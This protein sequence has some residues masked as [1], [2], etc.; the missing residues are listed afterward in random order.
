MTKR[1]FRSTFLAVAVVLVASIVIIMGVMYDYF[2]GVQW[3]Q[4]DAETELASSGVETGG[5]DYLNDLNLRDYRVTWIDSNGTVIFDNQANAGEMENHSD[6]TEVREALRTGAGKSTRYSSTLS[7]KTFYRAV[8]LSDGTVLRVSATQYSVFTILLGMLPPILGVVAVALILSAVI[9]RRLSKNIVEPINKIDFDHP[10]DNEA[11]EELAPFLSRIE[12]QH[13]Q[14]ESQMKDLEHMQ[15]EFLAVTESMNEG[16]ILLNEKG[17]VLSINKAARKLFSAEGS[18]VGKDILTIEWSLDVQRLLEKAVSGSHGEIMLE[19]DGREYQLDASPVMTGGGKVSGAVLLS[20]DVTEKAFSERQ[21]REFSANVSHELKTPLHSIMG[22]AELLENGLVKKEDV[23]HFIGTIRREA[24]RLVTLID[25]IIRLS[26]LDEGADMQRENVDLLAMSK[27]VAGDLKSAADAA[28]VTVSVDG[29][30]GVIS[31][32]RRLL[33]EIVFNL[34]ENAIKYNVRDGRVNIHVEDGKE[35]VSLTVS[36]TGIGV[37][38]EHQ[39]RIFERF[40]RVDKSHSR[41][42]G[43]TGLGLS[44]VKHAVQYHNGKIK[45]KSRMGEGTEIKIEFPKY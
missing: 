2:S 6:R 37:S 15:E 44:I 36:D 13:R 12:R 4:L 18:C 43:G 8:R 14:I 39:D 27:E 3:S 11:Y 38:Q 22:S 40:Y 35:R 17:I 5:I 7:E 25:D 10:L 16:L 21:R 30:P 31:G 33:Q 42:T 26:Q 9:S 19:R 24:A 41:E 20:F 45:I 29:D 28:G 32:V 1:I 23:P 34:C